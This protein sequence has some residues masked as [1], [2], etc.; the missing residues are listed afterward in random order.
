MDDPADQATLERL[1]ASGTVRAVHSQE[2]TLEEVFFDIAGVRRRLERS[3]Q[4]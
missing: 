4:S 2:A 3:V 1:L